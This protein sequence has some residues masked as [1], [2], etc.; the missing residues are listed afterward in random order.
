MNKICHTV[1][2]EWHASVGKP[3]WLQWESLESLW[4]REIAALRVVGHFPTRGVVEMPNIRSASKT[5]NI[6]CISFGQE[7]HF[8]L[9]TEFPNMPCDSGR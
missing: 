9:T 6:F 7:T 5:Y 8:D 4:I 2:R 1:D 3:S